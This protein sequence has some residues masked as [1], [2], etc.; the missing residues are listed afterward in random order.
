M[1][2][3]NLLMDSIVT[4]TNNGV[5][6]V[7]TGIGNR[8]ATELLQEI[9]KLDDNG[10]QELFFDNEKLRNYIAAHI[11]FSNDDMTTIQSDEDTVVKAL[12]SQQSKRSKSMALELNANSI[13]KVISSTVGEMLIREANNL[14]YNNRAAATKSYTSEELTEEVLQSYKEDQETLRKA[15]RNVQAKK[16]NI[17]KKMSSDGETEELVAQLQ[18]VE[19]CEELLFTVR[20][21][22]RKKPQ[23]KVDPRIDHIIGIFNANEIN[24]KMKKAE[25][26]DIINQVKEIVGYQEEVT[27]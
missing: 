6:V 21:T 13:A 12:K 15:I 5:S 27:E 20:T 22:E 2:M 18:E 24:D 9:S 26:M 17:K 10:I 1:K 11:D 16:C 14:P 25:L 4:K 3:K 23:Q 7:V 19:K 8:V